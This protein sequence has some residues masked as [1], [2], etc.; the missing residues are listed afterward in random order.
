MWNSKE[1][2]RELEYQ[3]RQLKQELSDLKTNF[4]EKLELAKATKE[5]ELE[6]DYAHEQHNLEEKY[7]KKLDALNDKM[8]ELAKEA[9]KAK[10]PVGTVVNNQS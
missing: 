3:I 6:R 9:I 10:T 8:F 5:A 1:T 2:I 4:N 7:G